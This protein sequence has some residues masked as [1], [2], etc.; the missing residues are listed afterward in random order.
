MISN[1]KADLKKHN[2][3]EQGAWG[4]EKAIGKKQKSIDSESILFQQLPLSG[5]G[6]SST[7]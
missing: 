2:G 3:R 1:E 4:R 5:G 6:G 7:I